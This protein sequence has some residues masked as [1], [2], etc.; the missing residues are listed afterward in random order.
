MTVSS[1]KFRF[2]LLFDKLE[3]LTN[4]SIHNIAKKNI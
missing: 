3:N 2:K 1:F 4:I